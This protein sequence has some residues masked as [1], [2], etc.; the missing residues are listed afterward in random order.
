M[1][2]NDR[3]GFNHHPASGASLPWLCSRLLSIIF[4]A[5]SGFF[6]ENLRDVLTIFLDKIL[7]KYFRERDVNEC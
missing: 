1:R 6:E 7:T 5:Y 3:F 2:Y 4:K